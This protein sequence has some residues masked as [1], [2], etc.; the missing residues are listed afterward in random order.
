M[1]QLRDE[2]SQAGGITT[3][4]FVPSHSIIEEPFQFGREDTC[5]GQSKGM[6]IRVRQVHVQK[7]EMIGQFLRCCGQTRHAIGDGVQGGQRRRMSSAKGGELVGNAGTAHLNHGEQ[8]PALGAE[9]LHQRGRGDASLGGDVGQGQTNGADP[10]DCAG[11]GVE[12]LDIG[13]RAA[14]R[15]H[16]AMINK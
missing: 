4:Q 14:A 10:T 2:T 5:M 13:D 15:T 1:N 12:Q 6:E 9:S 3:D 7:G 8:Q 16:P 11:G